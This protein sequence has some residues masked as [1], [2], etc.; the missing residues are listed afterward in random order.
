MQTP[1][2]SFSPERGWI[3]LYELEINVEAW[4]L[5]QFRTI[6]VR[7]GVGIAEVDVVQLNSHRGHGSG[8]RLPDRG[9]EVNAQ[10]IVGKQSR[11]CACRGE[12]EQQNSDDHA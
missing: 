1:V 9:T 8:M 11:R 3:S 5:G 7:N 2:I 12:G 10:R 4:K 6:L